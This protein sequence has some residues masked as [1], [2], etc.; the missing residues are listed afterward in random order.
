[1]KAFTRFLFENSPFEPSWTAL[2]CGYAVLGWWDGRMYLTDA[3]EEYLE[4]A[5]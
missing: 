5:E 1:M 2:I 3:G 4:G